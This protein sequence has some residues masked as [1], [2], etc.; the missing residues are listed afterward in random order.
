MADV[1][2]NSS[3]APANAKL[4]AIFDDPTNFNIKHPLQYVW[5]FW[6]RASTNKNSSASDD[7]N[8]SLEVISSCSTVEDFW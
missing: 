8:K 4:A 6:H 5:S 1:Q 7:W 2:N 3:I